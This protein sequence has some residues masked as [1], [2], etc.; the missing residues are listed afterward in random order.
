MAI[1]S[2]SNRRVFWAV[3]LVAFCAV[4]TIALYD[5]VDSEVGGI[6]RSGT[7]EASLDSDQS[8]P[9]YSRGPSVDLK[10]FIRYMYAGSYGMYWELEQKQQQKVLAPSD[11]LLLE[12][13]E[14]EISNDY[15]NDRF[16]DWFSS[17]LSLLQ[18]YSVEYQIKDT[19][20]EVSYTNS[21][22]NIAE[23]ENS[24]VPFFLKMTFDGE[25]NATLGSMSNMDNLEFTIS[26]I[27]GITKERFLSWF[28]VE[29]ISGS[30]L[31]QPENVEIYIYS[32]NSSCYYSEEDTDYVYGS[33]VRS[34]FSRFYIGAL[35]FLAACAF[36]IPVY[37]KLR[38]ETPLI[39]KIPLEGSIGIVFVVCLLEDFAGSLCANFINGGWAGNEFLHMLLN[40]AFYMVVYGAWFVAVMA[41]LQMIDVGPKTYVIER[42]VIRKTVNQVYGSGKG[43]VEHFIA[44]I[45]TIDL[46][47]KSD[48]WLLKVVGA[49]FVVLLVCCLLWFWGVF[50]LI[51]Y[52]VALFFILRKYL[53]GI[54]E[55][56]GILLSATRQMAEGNLQMDIEEDLGLFEPMKE[57]LSKV[58]SG[59]K[60]AVDAEIKS[61]NM[62]TELITNVSHDLKTPL[63]AIIT[64]VNLLKDE[65]ITPEERRNYVEILDRKS[66]RLKNL[67]E[68]LFEVSKA[69]SGNIKVEKTQVDLGEMVKQAAAE[70]QD[71]MKEAGIE[72]RISVP[73][74]RVLMELDSEKTY[75]IL[76]NLLVNVTKYS[77][78]GT[79]AWLSLAD[80]GKQAEIVLK[81]IS[82][83]ELDED[84]SR[85]TERFVRGDKARNTEGSGLGLAIVQSFVQIQGGS[86]QIVTDGD[87]FK[88]I[89]RFPKEG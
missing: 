89:V 29:G 16:K 12:N 3:L 17:F 54:K 49:N 51:V 40:F 19:Q 46:S 68:D 64:Y 7:E 15:F 55:K 62:K 82:A 77:L 70:Q 21:V 10:S 1:K 84:A 4:M 61:Q 34:V 18:E 73:E 41:L 56:Y 71:R 83:T 44:S 85:L 78:A 48:S 52:S 23:Y 38:R 50:G 80:D 66:L 65:T 58:N 60:K 22:Q 42:S 57:E 30:L 36:V 79:R 39:A 25:G 87:L 27:G 81:N 76:E 53:K 88:A 59:F 26:D 24:V 74:E 47:D 43:M 20:T 13:D 33:T 75:R 8:W 2:K 37:K 11:L 31:K 86:F 28:A 72:C 63:T 9:Y 45:K 6:S 32:S 14:T 67:I 5:A 35:L 69:A